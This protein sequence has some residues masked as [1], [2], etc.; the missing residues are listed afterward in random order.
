MMNNKVGYI[1]IIFIVLIVLSILFIFKYDK[2]DTKLI[3]SDWYRYNYK[4]GFY[5]HIYFDGLVFNYDIPK[6]INA[7]TSYDNC[8]SYSYSKKSKTFNF[9]CGKS[10]KIEK[11]SNNELIIKD[12]SE[13]KYFYKFIDESLNNE[14]NR[15]F[16]SS[17][18]EYKNQKSQ[19]L[20]L[21]KINPNFQLN[22]LLDTNDISKLVFVGD[23]CSAIDCT[24][25]L[26]VLEKWY[27]ISTN[28]YVI[29]STN[30]NINNLYKI[31]RDFKNYY[32]YNDIYPFIVILSNDKVIDAYN[33]KC[34]GFNCSKYYKY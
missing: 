20:E 23:N 16:G 25:M 13:V 31:S 22:D 32:N 33:L 7:N 3:N 6:S 34:D 28:S 26:D 19:V 8:F 9:D 12:D 17:I 21:L 1:L 10:I 4:N 30:L 11:V 5:E 29:D 24:L 2:I 18:I 15:Y 27:V 14:F